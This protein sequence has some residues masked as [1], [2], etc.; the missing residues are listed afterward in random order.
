MLKFTTSL[1]RS[2]RHLL[3]PVFLLAC[4]TR[5]ATTA[6]GAPPTAGEPLRIAVVAQVKEPGDKYVTRKVGEEEQP[7][8]AALSEVD[9]RARA[10]RDAMASIPTVVREIRLLQAAKRFMMGSAPPAGF[11]PDAWRAALEAPLYFSVDGMNEE[12]SW[13]GFTLRTPNGDVPQLATPFV[14]CNATEQQLRAGNIDG[15]FLHEIGHQLLYVALGAVMLPC[16]RSTDCFRAPSQVHDVQRPTQP[17]MA[18]NEGLAEY[19][20]TEEYLREP[21][22]RTLRH[23]L[24]TDRALQSARSYLSP[25]PRRDEIVVWNRALF[26]PTL[27]PTEALVSM[28]PDE[29]RIVTRNAQPFDDHRLRSCGEA[30]SVEGVVWPPC[31]CAWPWIRT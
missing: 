10:A 31:C 21:G 12:R 19:F 14:E 24:D 17:L 4:G 23:A 29:L 25:R 18:L 28:A 8:Y 30:L 7:V 20:Q 6:G 11:G 3:A 1:L 9:P 13:F 27:P 5:P 16:G 15:D 2:R 26:E 22:A